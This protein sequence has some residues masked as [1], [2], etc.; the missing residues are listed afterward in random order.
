[1]IF[2]KV[3]LIGNGFKREKG[4]GRNQIM[5][6]FSDTTDLDDFGNTLKL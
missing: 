5:Q 3:Y 4:S 6:K 2:L 1:M